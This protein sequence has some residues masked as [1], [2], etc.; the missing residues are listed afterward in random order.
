MA[1]F[2]KQKQSSV[3]IQPQEPNGKNTTQEVS[4][5]IVSTELFRPNKK[6]RKTPCKASD[7]NCKKKQN[8]KTERKEDLHYKLT[9]LERRSET[10][11]KRNKSL[12][13]KN[14]RL[15][16][17]VRNIAG[18]STPRSKTDKELRDWIITKKNSAKF[19]K[20]TYSCKHNGKRDQRIVE[21]NKFIRDYKHNNRENNQ[22][23]QNGVLS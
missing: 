11:S 1:I 7:K 5:M 2:F 23:L 21:G 17:K 14:Q 8:K 18:P 13:K 12:Q 6:S 20:K 15:D 22:K 9:K 10:L 4:K 19:K 3:Q 16:D